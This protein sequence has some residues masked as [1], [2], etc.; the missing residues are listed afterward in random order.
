[1]TL[2]DMLDPHWWTV[3]R[4]AMAALLAYIFLRLLK[5]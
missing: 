3:D 2:A 4:M 1:M 5:D